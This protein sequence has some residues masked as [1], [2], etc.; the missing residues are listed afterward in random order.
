MLS[1]LLSIR[2]LSPVLSILSICC[3]TE[4]T[5]LCAD[6]CAERWLCS[7]SV[8][9]MGSPKGTVGTPAETHDLL[10]AREHVN[11]MEVPP[12]AL[13][14]QYSRPSIDSTAG[15][16]AALFCCSAA[17]L[18]KFVI[19]LVSSVGVLRCLLEQTPP[20]ACLLLPRR[21]YASNQEES[22]CFALLCIPAA[23]TS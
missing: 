17:L 13:I 3:T 20:P 8:Y 23:V 16:A 19:W 5:N 12:P 9:G 2:L 6:C 21:P 14:A 10:L 22:R 18:L 7:V 4:H 11:F 1:R 15:M